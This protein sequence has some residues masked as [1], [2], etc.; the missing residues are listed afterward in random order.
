MPLHSVDLIVFILPPAVMLYYLLNRSGY[1]RVAV[2]ALVGLS[3]ALCGWH[4]FTDAGM[5]A[6]S[7]GFNF[8]VAVLMHRHSGQPRATRTALLA[9]GV[10]ANLSMLGYFKYS[11]FVTENLNAVLH[12]TY[13]LLTT[14]LPLGISFLTFQQIAYLVDVYRGHI[15]SF[16]FLD[17]CFLCS[18]FPKI[19]AGPIVRHGELVPQIAGPM[20]N[21]S[22][23]DLATGATRFTIGLFKKVVLADSLAAY[24]NPLFTAS[25][26]TGDVGMVEAWGGILAY[27]FQ[28]YFDFSGYTDMALGLAQLFGVSLPENF[29]SPYKATS[30]IDFWKR[31]HMT[32]SR[33]LR[34]YLYIPLGG[35]RQGP[36]R[37]QVN[38]L[39]TMVLC[40]LWHGPSWT[41]VIWGALHG[42]YLLINHTWRRLS[43]SCP[44]AIG[45]GLTFLSVALGWAWFRAENL[46]A[47]TRL[48]ASLFGVNGLWTQGL[49]TTLRYLEVPAPQ[50]ET[51]ARFFGHDLGL[52]VSI[53]RWTIYP[54]NL[55]LSNP[56]LQICWLVVS[57]MIVLQL[58][59]AAEWIRATPQT[60]EHPLTLRRALVVGLLLFLVWL[61][62]ISSQTSGF[63]YENF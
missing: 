54:A 9:I 43:F 49:H 41:F 60:S 50:L 48:T 32:L 37:Q 33:F 59:N 21:V 23:D 25:A 20:P 8:L 62:S 45:W 7:I 18:F 56:A 42:V 44:P 38:L 16:N 47:A 31:W 22:L 11:A 13:P 3:F 55:L 36:R 46:S 52:V 51:V 19:L 30:I 61:A 53:G 26:A 63:I 28:I 29:N 34:D 27:T 39:I 57:G 6:G 2:A 24:A 58:P 10:T 1:F 15:K 17:Y 12:T 5:L 14:Y 4:A 35:N 40:G